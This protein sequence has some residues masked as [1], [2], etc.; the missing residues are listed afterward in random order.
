MDGLL[1]KIYTIENCALL[2]YYEASSGDFTG[3]DDH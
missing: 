2:G 3:Q 1:H